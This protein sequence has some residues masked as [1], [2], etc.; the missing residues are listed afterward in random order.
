VKKPPS[1]AAARIEALR[2]AYRQFVDDLKS[3]AR[4]LAQDDSDS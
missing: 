4:Y 1:N 2:E 3:A